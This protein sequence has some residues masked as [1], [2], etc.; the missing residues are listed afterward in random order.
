MVETYTSSGK[1]LANQYLEGFLQNDNVLVGF[2]MPYIAQLQGSWDRVTEI[3]NM[4]VK[5][6]K[7]EIIGF[8]RNYDRMRDLVFYASMNM[9]ASV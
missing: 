8:L 9:A 3:G 5:L 6:P 7:A 2:L 4:M 1:A